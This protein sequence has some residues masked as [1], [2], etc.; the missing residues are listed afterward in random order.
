MAA[1]TT[2]EVDYIPAAGLFVASCGCGW[3][4]EPSRSL[5]AAVVAFTGHRRSS[6]L[7]E[8]PDPMETSDGRQ[9]AERTQA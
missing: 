2:H 8:H 7:M 5:S 1:P 9:G 4:S 6:D 3:E